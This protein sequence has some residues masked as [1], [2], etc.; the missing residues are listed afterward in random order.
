[1][2]ELTLKKIWREYYK[3]CNKNVKDIEENQF[4]NAVEYILDENMELIENKNVGSEDNKYGMIVWKIK[5]NTPEYPNGREIIVIANDITFDSGSFGVM[6]DMIFHKGSLLARKLRLPRIFITGNAGARI[7]LAEEV[8][9]VYKIAFVNE[10]DPSKGVKYLYLSESDYNVMKESV[11]VEEI[12]DNNEK[13][14]KILDII[15]KQDGIGVENLKGSGLIAGETSLAYKDIFT[16]SYVASRTVGIGA[17]LVRLGQRVIQYKKTPIILTGAV[18]LNKVL[19]K[20]VYTSNLQLGGTQIM[21]NNGVSHLVV[22]NDFK[23]ILN[24]LKWISFIPKMAGSPLPVLTDMTDKIDREVEFTPIKDQQYDPRFLI[25]GCQKED[26]W[27]SGFFDKGSF[28]ETLG[29][30]KIN[31]KRLGKECSDRKSKIR[32]NTGWN[33]ISRDQNNGI[34]DTSRSSRC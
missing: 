21:Y 9:N 4:S 34:S 23:G 13:R 32:R 12:F 25:E 33:N 18:A 2:F 6:E 1:L 11:H 14:F 31:K 29:G 22:D 8:K 15:G 24:V 5:L 3:K 30:K 20:T 28:I 17:Y 10:K 19:G 16:I 27:Y 7:G 26:K